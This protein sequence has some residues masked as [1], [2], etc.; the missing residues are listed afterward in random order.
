MTII[1]DVDDNKKIEKI[2]YTEVEDLNTL[3]EMRILKEVKLPI[4]AIK[5]N[6]GDKNSKKTI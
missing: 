4:P 5:I 3:S 2:T 6:K 1:I